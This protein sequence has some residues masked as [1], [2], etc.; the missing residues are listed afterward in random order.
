M[1]QSCGRM[2]TDGREQMQAWRA[3]SFRHAD[4]FETHCQPESELS[5]WK[6][7][8]F[9][10]GFDDMK[11]DG[12]GDRHLG[13][14]IDEDTEPYDASA[15]FQ[16]GDDANAVD[17]LR[18]YVLE[19]G[20]HPPRPSACCDKPQFL[21]SC[22]VIVVCVCFLR[23]SPPCTLPFP[24]HGDPFPDIPGRLW[25]LHMALLLGSR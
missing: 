21:C 19:V 16:Q 9:L 11:A 24:L 10:Q 14:T 8:R 1:Q 23:I 3:F 6:Q 2:D 22:L 15:P 20:L 12:G 7:V 17:V 13:L 25:V 18:L 4:C 5:T